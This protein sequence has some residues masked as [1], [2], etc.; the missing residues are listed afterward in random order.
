[1]TPTAGALQEN[2][3]LTELKQFFLDTTKYGVAI[4]FPITLIL[5]TFG[6]I[7]ITLWMGSQYAHNGVLTI[8]AIGY[9]LPTSQSSVMRILIGIN[10]HG[11]IGLISLLVSLT[12]FALGMIVVNATGWSLVNGALLI[13]IPLTIGNGIVVPVYACR[14]F[15][16]PLMEYILYI[17]YVP[18]LCSLALG[19]I[20]FFSRILFPDNMYAMLGFGSV[21]GCLVTGGLYWCFILPESFRMKIRH[22]LYRYFPVLKNGKNA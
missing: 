4:L 13:A 16:I 9:F 17:F 5:V 12:V 1:M 21:V 8:L 19:V 3:Q 10:L 15:N 11:R 7:I 14:Q 20:L 2:G 18:F 22:I 6:D